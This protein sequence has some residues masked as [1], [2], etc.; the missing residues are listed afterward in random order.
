[1]FSVIDQYKV[2]IFKDNYRL[3]PV[4]NYIPSHKLNFADVDDIKQKTKLT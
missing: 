1:M 2:F 4:F 3:Q